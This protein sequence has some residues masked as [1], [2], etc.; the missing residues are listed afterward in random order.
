[1]KSRKI[2]YSL[3]LSVLLSIILNPSFSAQSEFSNEKIWGGEF[4]SESVWG[5]RSMADGSSYTA[6]ENDAELGSVIVQYSYKSGKRLK[7]IASSHA[8]FNS[9]DVRISGYTFS[10][11][12]RYILLTTARE[13]IYR[14]SYFADYYIYDTKSNEAAKPL[15]EFSQGKQRL[16]TFSPSADKVAFVRD[17]N[18]FIAN[19]IN[20]SETQVTNDGLFNHIINGATDWVYEEEF[21]DDRGLKWSSDGEKLAYYKFDESGVKEFHMPVYGGLYPELYTFITQRLMSLFTT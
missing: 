2:T 12:E 21:G 10:E 3:L 11:N 13:S 14:H 5:I 17:N 9:I 8:A 1:M 15:T 20:G 4:W 7:T 18:I 6:M 16:A 19:L